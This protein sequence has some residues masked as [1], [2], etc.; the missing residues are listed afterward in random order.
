MLSFV[1]EWAPFLSVFVWNRKDNDDDDDDD[2]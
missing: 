1:V 2:P